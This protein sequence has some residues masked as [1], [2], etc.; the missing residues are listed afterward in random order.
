MSNRRGS[1]LLIVLGFLS[2]MVVS[3]VAFSIWMRSE[4]VPSAVF[5]REAALR[6]LAKAGLARA[7]SEIDDA[8]RNNPYPGVIKTS[9]RNAY[10]LEFN[11]WEGRLFVPPDPDDANCQYY[12]VSR[13]ETVSVLN[14]EGLG[15]LPP[16]LMNDVRLRQQS[17][18][19][20]KWRYLDHGAGRCAYVAVNVSDLIDINRT[21]LDAA[22]TSLRPITL[23]NL[24]MNQSGQIDSGKVTSFGNFAR[25]PANNDN[26]GNKVVAGTQ[27]VS[28]LDY[29]LALFGAG[30]V[31]DFE[32]PFAKWL[33]KSSSRGFYEDFR[34]DGDDFPSVRQQMFVT[35]SHYPRSPEEE[36]SGTARPSLAVMEGDRKV[37]GQPFDL[38]TF[39]DLRQKKT[40][41]ELLNALNQMPDAKSENGV[42]FSDMFTNPDLVALYDYLDRDDI[43][44]S[45]AL[46]TVE[47]NPMVV[48]IEPNLNGV[49]IVVPKVELATATASAPSVTTDVAWDTSTLGAFDLKMVLAYPFKRTQMGTANFRRSYKVQAIVK[50]F[51][52]PRDSAVPLRGDRMS[53]NAAFRPGNS[54][55]TQSAINSLGAN[56]NVLTFVGSQSFSPDDNL[57]KEV[58]VNVTRSGPVP[59]AQFVSTWNPGNPEQGVPGFAENKWKLLFAPSDLSGGVPNGYALNTEATSLPTGDLVPVMATWV[60]V[61]SNDGFVADCVPATIRD[62]QD[63]NGIDNTSAQMIFEGMGTQKEPLLRFTTDQSVTLNFNAMQTAMAAGQDYRP[64]LM[65]WGQKAIWAVDPR[66]NFAPEDWVASNSGVNADDWENKANAASGSNDCDGDPYLFVSNQGFLQSMGE[67]AFL[68]RTGGNFASVPDSDWGGLAARYAGKNEYA[69]AWTDI[70]AANLVWRSYCPWDENDKLFDCG[71]SEAAGGTRVSPYADVDTIMLALA[72]TPVDWWAA[73]GTNTVVDAAN[74]QNT[75]DSAGRRAGYFNSLAQS[76]KFAFNKTGSASSEDRE[77]DYEDLKK[78]AQFMHNEFI[79]SNDDWQKVYDS[80]DWTPNGTPFSA[81]S[82]FKNQLDSVDCKFLHSFWRNCF[83]NRQ[84]LFIVFVRAESTALG[85]SGEGGVPP[86]QG[87]RAVAVVW[88]DPDPFV[89]HKGRDNNSPESR[90][91]H[92]MRVLFYHQFD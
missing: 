82:N 4:R 44:T 48:A 56:N 79:N 67:L 58:T 22:R 16:F 70:A 77:L 65:V 11:H 25:S 1:A 9:H 42:N 32:S 84:Q 69:T 78:L 89:S 68:P 43:P 47:R 71:I 29:N 92:R 90:A 24:F 91:S 19:T 2:F 13:D 20:A 63:F 83:A 40:V 14:L 60:R 36:E 21:G 26:Y 55:Y 6:H 72:N 73:A 45:L 50:I 49:E 54:D 87:A 52:V 74:G 34:G 27:F 28:L 23:A 17:T 59:M 18:R 12:P 37:R 76:L 86:Q 33:G 8:I 75:A 35:E 51:F 38:A 41:M 53:S 80:W 15:Y 85:G 62:D 10:G 39:N 5:R 64:G 81:T 66:Y 57:A 46:P 7:M 61:Q 31:G 3:A 30:K 88:R